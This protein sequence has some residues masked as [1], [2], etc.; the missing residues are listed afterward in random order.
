[1]NRTL[2]PSLRT[3]I[4]GKSTLLPSGRTA[5]SG[6][7]ADTFG[8]VN[9]I[10]SPV[11]DQTGFE[12]APEEM[13]TGTPPST[14]ILKSP[15]PAVSSPPVTIHLPSGDQSGAPRTLMVSAIGCNSL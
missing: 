3:S 6:A 14:G 15:A 11:G 5:L 1:M 13:R 7:T 4:T 12:Q 2:W 9:T 8:P 10:K